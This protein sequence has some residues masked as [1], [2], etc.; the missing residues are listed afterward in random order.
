MNKS[1]YRERI[2]QL[3][4]EAFSIPPPPPV[5]ACASCEHLNTD[6]MCDRLVEYPPLGFIAQ[7]NECADYYEVIPF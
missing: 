2:A 6:G 5:R 7:P 4:A 3:K 1:E